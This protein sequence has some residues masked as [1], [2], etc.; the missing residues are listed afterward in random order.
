VLV[1]VLALA[2]VVAA[3]WWVQRGALQP[4]HDDPYNIEVLG[5]G[6]DRVTLARTRYDAEL[7]RFRLEWVGGSALVADILGRNDHQVVRALGQQTGTPLKTGLRVRLENPYRGDP[8]TALGLGFDEVRLADR[9]GPLPE[10]VVP[11]SSPIWAIIVHGWSG[12]RHDGLYLLPALHALGIPAMLISYRNDVGAA[13]G[14]GGLVHFGQTE[15][16]DVD[17]AVAYARAHGASGVVLIGASMGG[18][19]VSEYVRHSSQASFVRGLVLDAPELDL[20]PDMRFGARAHGLRGPLN[21]VVIGA[22]QLAMRLRAGINFGELDQIAHARDFRLPVLLYQGDADDAVP[23]S[24][25][26]AFARARPDLVTYVRVHGAGHVAA[27]NVDPT[28]YEQSLHD[29]IQ[30]LTPNAPP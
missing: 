7:G 11:G 12:S 5:T 21:W 28:R 14:P 10:W 6:P 26:D 13:R 15:W 9:L 17:P 4:S 18:A 25:A 23:V 29:F 20:A 8:R 30:R 27:W 19:V 2:A 16:A 22:G 3:G 24:G 1:T